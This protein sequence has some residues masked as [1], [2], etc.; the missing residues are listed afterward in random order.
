MKPR[1]HHHLVEDAHK[2]IVSVDFIVA[3]NAIGAYEAAEDDALEDEDPVPEE[4]EEVFP[5]LDNLKDT[6]SNEGD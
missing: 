3:Y 4:S 6:R 5:L 1:D 2:G